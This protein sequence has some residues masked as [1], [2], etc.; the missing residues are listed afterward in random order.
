M[1]RLDLTN[2]TVEVRNEEEEYRLKDGRGPFPSIQACLDALGVDQADRPSLNRWDRLSKELKDQIE[3]IEVVEMPY[4]VKPS[5]IEL[6]F[7]RELHLSGIE[8]L[9]RD[10][11][12]RKVKDCDGVLLLEETDW[13]KLKTSAESTTGFSRPDVELIRRILNAEE[14]EVEEKAP[15]EPQAEVPAEPIATEEKP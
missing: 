14:V 13:Q 12:A 8:L 7:S 6:M 15:A 10:D 2:Y 9:E 3:P 4:E 11:L 5:L 1:R